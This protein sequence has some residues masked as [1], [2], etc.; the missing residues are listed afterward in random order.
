MLI[1]G[2]GIFLFA[3]CAIAGL[4]IFSRGVGVEIGPDDISDTASIDITQGAAFGLAGA[5]YM[6]GKTAVIDVSAPGFHSARWQLD[7]A[8]F[9]T[10]IRIELK[11]LPGEII[12]ETQPAQADT[13]WMID[14]IPV[15]TGPSLRQTIEPG[16]YRIAAVHPFFLPVSQDIVVTRATP[17]RLT[18]TL[19][20]VDGRLEINT[21]PPGARVMID[22]IEVGTTPLSLPQPGGQYRLDISHD[23]FGP[24]RDRVQITHQAPTVTRN[25]R[26]KKIAAHLQ[27]N[28]TPKGGIL[29][30]NGIKQSPGEILALA[31]DAGTDYDIHY[32]KPG[33]VAFRDRISL[34][35]GSR[36]EL[37]ITLKASFGTVDIASTPKAALFIDGQPRGQTP[38]SL[39]L[40]TRKAV[41][42]LRK[43]GFVPHQQTILPV[44]GK[45]IRIDQILVRERDARLAAAPEYYKNSIGMELR[46][47]EPGSFIM[48]APRAQKGQRANEFLREVRLTRHFYA[49]LYEVTNQDFA[50]IMPGFTI[51]GDQNHP[52]T[53]ITWQQAARFCNRLSKAENLHPFYKFIPGGGVRVNPHADGYRLLSEAEWEW[54]AR[55]AGR[56]SH[57]VFPWGDNETVPANIGNIADESAK[58][59]VDFYVPNYDDGFATTAPVG[60]FP[61]EASG[62]YDLTGNV[63]EWVHDHYSLSPPDSTQMDPL[64]P[65]FGTTHVVKGSSFRS[66]DRT[67]LRPAWREGFV[68]TRDDI[69]FRIGRYIYGDDDAKNTSEN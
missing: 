6:I 49:G 65:A 61:A 68:G 3:A 51:K 33:Y 50:K 43:T 5:V 60:S 35:P 41:L 67:V 11:P 9:G 29:L 13:T 30:V 36:R 27:V 21:Q 58:G 48:G 10:T 22:D 25:Y 66:G 40:P 63:S 57:V 7:A 32:E 16:T 14:R 31:G 46:L 69:G 28:V 64:G 55:R 47:F 23:G 38:A 44:R 45:T 1:G 34:P 4:I 8:S 15:H 56:K 24:V 62:L 59:E 2:G 19:M 54:L 42:S 18:L 39:S 37:D 53:N 52:V 12:A 26:L 20:P 17:T